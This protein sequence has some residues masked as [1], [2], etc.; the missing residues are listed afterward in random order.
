MNYV[1]LKGFEDVQDTLLSDQLESNL[2]SWFQWGL[3]QKGAFWTVG[4]P[5]SGTFGG[6]THRLRSVTDPNY[7]QGQVWEAYRNDWCFETG[8]GYQYRDPIRVSGV[9]VNGGFHPLNSTG[10]YAHRIDYRW[11]RVVFDSPIPASSVV[12]AEYSHRLF[13]FAPASAPWWRQVQTNS[14]RV[15]SPAYLQGS[16]AYS[17]LAQNRVQLPAVVVHVIPNSRRFGKEV[18]SRSNI[19][20]QNVLFEI[21]TETKSDCD[22]LH[23]IIM[24]QQDQTVMLYSR[25][26]VLIDER[27]VL[28]AYGSPAPSGL[29]YPQLLDQYPW[30][31]ATV[32]QMIST[33]QPVVVTHPL[34][35]ATVRCTIEIDL[36]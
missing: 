2:V 15:D 27:F 8:V 19:V 13:H 29:M 35:A 26:Q 5:S 12:T 10:T 36:P 25:D 9:Y 30:R 17:I 6:N 16:G 28:D 14:Y 34:H 4:I 24:A 32:K 31:K 22:K 11:G 1:P 3:L 23:D 20:Q 7:Q 18:G 33:D 21:L